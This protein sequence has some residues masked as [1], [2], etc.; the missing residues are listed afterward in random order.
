MKNEY[1]SAGDLGYNDKDGY[2][3]PVDRKA[4]MIISGGENIYRSEVGNCEGKHPKVKD[5]AVKYQATFEFGLHTSISDYFNAIAGCSYN[6][7]G[8]HQ[9]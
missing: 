8:R 5:V 4:N 6:L 3:F 7:D 2:L 1:F 9:V